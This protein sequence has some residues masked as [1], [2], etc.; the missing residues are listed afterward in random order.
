[1]TGDEIVN[2]FIDRLNFHMKSNASIQ[3]DPYKGDFFKLFREAW[4]DR[5]FDVMARPRLAC[6]ALSD[7]LRDRWEPAGTPEGRHLVEKVFAMWD[8][9]RYAW[10][11]W[12]RVPPSPQGTSTNG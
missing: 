3:Q 1:M 11:A 12:E 6:D 5:H 10:D 4:Q 9:W 8:E 7:R 2:H